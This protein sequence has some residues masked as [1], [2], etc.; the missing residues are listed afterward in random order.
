MSDKSL[1]DK[2]FKISDKVRKLIKVA[3][4][5]FDGPETTEGYKRAE[6]I[7]RDPIISLALLKK[8]NNFFR[9][10]DE[11]S[12]SYRLTGGDEGK[13]YFAHLEE[14][15]RSGEESKRKT[16]SQVLDNQYKD[17]HTKD[18][19]N[20][21]TTKVNVPKVDTTSSLREEI[22]RINKLINS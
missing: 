8:I 2:T 5:S 13:K 1:Y 4:D 21:D 9:N 17:S 20:V 15:T 11:E 7:L 3:Y 19:N 18:G 16:K 10:V 12:M 6:N 14:K 22:K